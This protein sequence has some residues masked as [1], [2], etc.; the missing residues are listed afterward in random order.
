[1]AQV[2]GVAAGKLDHPMTVLVLMETGDRYGFGGNPSVR[3]VFAFGR[4][5][6]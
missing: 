1:M 3:V 2:L 4:L 6:R 5:L